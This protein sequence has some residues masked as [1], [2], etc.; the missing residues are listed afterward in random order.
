MTTLSRLRGGTRRGVHV[1]SGHLWRDFNDPWLVDD[2][3]C[4][5]ALLYNPNNPCLVTFTILGGLYLCTEP[6]RLL[7]W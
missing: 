7:T 1:L 3:G 5:V 4:A 6:S 2:P